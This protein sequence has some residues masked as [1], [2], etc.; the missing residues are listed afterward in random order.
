MNNVLDSSLSH[1]FFGKSPPLVHNYNFPA[2]EMA[3]LGK[4]I[5]KKPGQPQHLCTFHVTAGIC[6]ELSRLQTVFPPID[7]SAEPHSNIHTG[8]KWQNTGLRMNSLCSPRKQRYQF[9]T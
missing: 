5:G 7:F 6:H 1:I 2:L 4:K 3:P 8:K 9:V